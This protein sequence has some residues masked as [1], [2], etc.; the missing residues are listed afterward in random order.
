MGDHGSLLDELKLNTETLKEVC[1]SI[2][3]SSEGSGG[4]GGGVLGSS[5]QV[6]FTKNDD[7]RLLQQR[8]YYNK[9]EEGNRYI[10]ELKAIE[11]EYFETK[12]GPEIYKYIMEERKKYENKMWMGGS[13][14]ATSSTD[15][16]SELDLYH[17]LYNDVS[18]ATQLKEIK[19]N[20]DVLE[21]DVRDMVNETETNKR[22]I[23]YRH[24]VSE[25]ALSQSVKITYIYYFL[26]AC[27]F[28]LLISKN[29]LHAKDHIMLY[30]FVILFPFLYRY[31]FMGLVYA[32]NIL[33][34]L[35]NIHGPKNAFLDKA[36]DL[37]FL[38]DYDV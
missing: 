7:D 6:D 26:I 8:K 36:V 16:M 11:K 34:E 24:D 4:S 12:Y 9:V 17:K 32:Y 1:P 30:S 20:I 31:V 21:D 23:E 15:I 25:Q 5:I 3:S 37:Q 14:D 38:D 2:F 18:G 22:K 19:N 33:Y 27:I 28:I 29:A 10:V 35:F 13:D